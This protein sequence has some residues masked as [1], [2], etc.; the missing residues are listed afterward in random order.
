MS[1]E[2]KYEY[3]YESLQIDVSQPYMFAN[4]LCVNHNIPINYLCYEWKKYRVPVLQIMDTDL[5]PK[6][7]VQYVQSKQ[8]IMTRIQKQ[9][10]EDTVSCCM[11]K[12]VD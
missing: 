11:L 7:S 12:V 10:F 2:Y 1:I 8:I 4:R 3:K 6:S 5:A 9:S